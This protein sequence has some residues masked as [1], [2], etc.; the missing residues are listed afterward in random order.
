MATATRSSSQT[1]YAGQDPRG[2]PQGEKEEIPDNQ[3]GGVQESRDEEHTPPTNQESNAKDPNLV[4]WEENDLENPRNWSTAYK[5][6]ITFQL[7]MLALSA[8]LGSSIISPAENVISEYIGVSK[9]VTVLV[10]SLYM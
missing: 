4:D 3:Q 8:S 7:G 10:I 9:E 2:G 5:C 1:T 6:W